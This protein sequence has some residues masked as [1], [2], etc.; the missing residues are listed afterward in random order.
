VIT[1]ADEG[2]PPAPS[3]FEWPARACVSPPAGYA[4][5]LY[6]ARRVKARGPQNAR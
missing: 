3:R 4:A 2:R 1:A 6:T 5:A